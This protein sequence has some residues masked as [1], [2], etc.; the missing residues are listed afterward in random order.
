VNPT[1]IS[2]ALVACACCAPAA[3]AVSSADARAVCA[4]SLAIVTA[5]D[6]RATAIDSDLVATLVGKTIPAPPGVGLG[7][8]TMTLRERDVRAWLER[9]RAELANLVRIV[10]QDVARLADA[11]AADAVAGSCFDSRSKAVNQLWLAEATAIAKRVL[12]LRNSLTTATAQDGRDYTQANA[13]ADAAAKQARLQ[14][15]DSAIRARFDAASADYQREFDAAKAVRVRL[16]REVYDWR[17]EAKRVGHEQW[18]Q[19]FDI[20]LGL[21]DNEGALTEA[22]IVF[23]AGIAF[24]VPATHPDFQ[25]S[26]SPETWNMSRVVEPAVAELFRGGATFP[27]G[28]VEVRFVSPETGGYLL[29][30]DVEPREAFYVEVRYQE[31]QTTQA[32]EVAL[33]WPGGQASVLALPTDRPL[34]FRTGV[35][36]IDGL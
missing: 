30:L 24:A 14:A 1:S 3:A 4:A 29:L 2:V 34:V 5:A 6:A 11:S 26:T 13:L 12:V 10:P 21:F 25:A 16:A 19:F 22:G 36:M 18:E 8:T 9:P 28:P 35:L 27:D 20:Q 17:A 7:V 23:R 31:P 33:S 15:L 32:K